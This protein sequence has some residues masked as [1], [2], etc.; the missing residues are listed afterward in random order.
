MVHVL[1]NGDELE[2]HRS[3]SGLTSDHV[4]NFATHGNGEE[5]GLSGEHL[6]GVDRGL[7]LDRVV[8]VQGPS[9]AVM[10]LGRS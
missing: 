4:G 6:G 9:D 7:D 1:Q 8:G 2:L 5:F 10:N 3:R